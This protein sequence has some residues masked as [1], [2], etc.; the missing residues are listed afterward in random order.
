MIRRRAIPD[1]GGDED[2]A[3]WV[4]SDKFGEKVERIVMLLSIW[5][6]SSEGRFLMLQTLPISIS[7]VLSS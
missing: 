4:P 5:L 3:R 6:S 1:D 2:S 7:V